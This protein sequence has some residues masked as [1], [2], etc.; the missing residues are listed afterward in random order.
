MNTEPIVG[1]CLMVVAAGCTALWT[2]P[3]HGAVAEKPTTCTFKGITVRIE[4]GLTTGTVTA[5]F[6]Q[7]N[8]EDGDLRRPGTRPGRDRAGEV[9]GRPRHRHRFVRRRQGRVHAQFEFPT[10]DG[11]LTLTDEG[12]FPWGRLQGGPLGGELYCDRV[13]G[14]FWPCPRK[15]TASPAPCPQQPPTVP[16]RSISAAGNRTAGSDRVPSSWLDSSGVL[17]SRLG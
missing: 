5:R 12:Q 4:P 1:T 6:G 2:P 13:K 7:T 15:A 11:P 10:A 8:P 16:E 17:P 14:S 3:A 9:D